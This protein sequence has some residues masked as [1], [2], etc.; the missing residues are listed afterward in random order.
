LPSMD[1]T[2]HFLFD[3]KSKP[4]TPIT[5]GRLSGRQLEKMAS[6]NWQQQLGALGNFDNRG[7]AGQMRSLSNG[8]DVKVI[9]DGQ[10]LNNGNIKMNPG[11]IE[12]IQVI[13]R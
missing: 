10:V 13:K 11:S 5:I 12:S 2:I 9:V 3:H 7:N 6:T 8:G 1:Y 4:K